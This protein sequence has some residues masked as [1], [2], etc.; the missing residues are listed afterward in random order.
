MSAAVERDSRFGL[1][2]SLVGRLQANIDL[3]W[4]K[5]LRT[6]DGLMGATVRLLQRFQICLTGRI[7]RK[8]KLFGCCAEH[9]AGRCL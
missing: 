2:D 6:E 7:Q 4:V 3:D 1:E 5:F 9:G 8:F